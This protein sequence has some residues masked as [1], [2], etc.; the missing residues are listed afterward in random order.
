MK[1]QKTTVLVAVLITLSFSLKSQNNNV[2]IGTSTPDASAIL[3]L[4]SDNQG[5][6][7]PRITLTDLD[8]SSP[9]SNPA[10]GL[11]IYNTGGS[12]ENG[13]YYWNG[14]EWRLIGQEGG[15][16]ISECY[17]LQDSYECGGADNGGV[18]NTL[19]DAPLMINSSI[20]AN[21][22]LQIVH[23]GNGIC[24]SAG[25][26]SASGSYAAV[27]ATTNSNSGSAAIY[28]LTYGN[29]YGLRGDVDAASSGEAAI[30]GQNNRTAGGHGVM[31]LGVNGVVGQSNYVD[32]FGCYGFN[33]STTD[34]GIGTYGGGITGVAGQST[35]ISLSYGL[36][37][38]DDCGIYNH[39]DIGGN[40]YAGGTKSFRIDHPKDPDNKFLVHFC[41]ESNEILN[42]YRGIA[43]LDNN[44]E[45]VI[46]LPKYFDAV[47]TNYSYQLTPVGAAM[48]N[49]Y[50]SNE[51]NDNKF[52]VA[53]GV[54][55]AKVSW[56]VVAERDD[57]LI[58]N[59]L[60]AKESE[61][62]KTGRYKGKYVHPQFYSKSANS[63]ILYKQ[64]PKENFLLQIEQNE[65]NILKNK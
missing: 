25:N 32:G 36:Y 12:I 46:T 50:V 45:A 7:I 24:L 34:P 61:P 1:F 2:G 33:Y 9:V 30:Y 22:A 60:E 47:N 58:R 4:K 8:N 29:G 21:P 19:A 28:G 16:S 18:I 57:E 53:G 54:A 40:L 65:Q 23:S 15:G 14:S 59:N 10:I 55:G 62:L 48:P 38:F 31:G 13:F 37:S 56:T 26:T 52:A 5:I 27:Q 3:D 64:S 41:I 35:N 11:M 39:I 49:L 20:N 51:I 43:E 6:L 17:G 44:G 63:G 42:M